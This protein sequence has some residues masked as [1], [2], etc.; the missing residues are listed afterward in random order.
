MKGHYVIQFREDGKYLKSCRV[1]R[2]KNGDYKAHRTV[3][4]DDITQAKVYRSRKFAHKTIILYGMG[5][6]NTKI[7]KVDEDEISNRLEEE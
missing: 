4:T 3:W 6:V 1:D 2:K 7:V 5:V